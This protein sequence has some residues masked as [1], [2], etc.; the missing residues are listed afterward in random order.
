MGSLVHFI[1]TLSAARYGL[2]I[3]EVQPP[4]SV[5]GV[6][7]G[8]VGIV[9]NFPWG[10]ASQIVPIADAASA[11]E[12]YC[13]S[14][15]G[16][17]ALRA[18]AAMKA[19]ANK[20]Y[21]SLRIARIATT[22]AATATRTY[23]DAGVPSASVV[24]SAK[25]PG[26]LGNSVSIAWSNNVDDATARDATVA[27]GTTYSVLYPSVARIVATVL[28][29]TDPLDPFVVFAK[30][31]A[32][33][34]VPAAAAA[35]ALAGGADGVAV[36]GDYAAAIELFA[37][38]EI[39]CD[40]GFVAEPETA[41][42]TVVNDAVETFVNT[43][44]K[45]VWILATPA[46]QAFATAKTYAATYRSDRLI[47]PW[48]RVKMIDVF[49]PNRAQITVQGNA[50]AAA[51][52]AS[53]DPEKSPGGKPGARYLRGITA[54]EF[55][56]SA[57]QLNDLNASGV[58]PFF[59]STALEG[60]ILHNCVQTTLTVGLTKTFRRRMTDFVLKSLGNLFEL[61]VGE[62]LDLSLNPQ[63]LGP[64]T[65]PEFKAAESFLADLKERKR[66]EDYAIDAFGG[67][68]QSNLNAGIWIVILA[69][70]LFGAQEKI[71]L[72]ATI[73]ETITI[74]VAT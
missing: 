49:D 55:G 68:T 30:S 14:A 1:S 53:V 4:P 3:L 43:H 51:A 24:V 9:G 36:V 26:L 5:Q 28:T 42:L 66:I 69:V 54:T 2:N 17:T 70:K 13:P 29:V 31:G 10:P 25:F 8:T 74:E 67:N 38:Q 63:E 7:T 46:A 15:F 40:V 58:T 11:F 22:G 16:T 37:A 65:G 20:T 56:A 12:T 50:F 34:L 6:G 45:G 48:P 47:Y 62:P 61:Y 18:Y 52:V 44:S 71:V 57:A 60:A 33:T 32:A 41:I 72:K 19:L 73:G 35:V 59:M 23:N 21:P 39:E 64:V 27:I